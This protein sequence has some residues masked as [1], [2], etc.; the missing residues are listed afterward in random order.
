MVISFEKKDFFV[1]F[2]LKK[3]F[4]CKFFVVWVNII[5][6]VVL[7]LIVEFFFFYVL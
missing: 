6:I 3:L 7:G 1:G 4:S 5:L 2:L